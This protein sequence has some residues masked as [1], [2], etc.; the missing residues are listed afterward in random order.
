MPITTDAVERQLALDEHLAAVLDA[1]ERDLVKAWALAWDE[2]AGDLRDTLAAIAEKYDE[3]EP[4]PRSAFARSARLT[5]ILAH[6]SD[7]LD[8]LA[9]DLGVRVVR[10]VAS[11]TRR[12]ADAQAEI[13]SAMLPPE[14]RL[15]KLTH[16]DTLALDAIVKRTTQQITS[17]RW[18]LSPRAYSA[19][20]RELVRGIAA[21]S[22][23]REVADRMVTRAHD[24]FDGGLA[25]AVNIA[26]TE[27]VDA[28][29]EAARVG[30]QRHAD[31]IAEWV[32]LAHLS[33]RTCR[34]C[35]GQNGTRHPM[36][37][38]GPLDHQS[39]RCSR[40]PVPKTWAE[41]GF[42]ELDEPDDDGVPDAEEW[43]ASLTEAEQR[44]ILGPRGFVAWRRGDYPM[45][46]WARRRRT[47]GWRDSF[48][49][50]TPP[51][52]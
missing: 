8:Q 40:M 22:G 25:R 38:P 36:S 39:G 1:Q 30:Q 52:V 42:D 44:R 49:P 31:V 47:S 48:V 50:S 29:R 19:V 15:T 12:A 26:R 46:E 33:P 2:V 14:F 21:G 35:I 20:R 41:L 7:Q 28:H 17:P 16:D 3:G 11:V 27:M 18:H 10:D 9:T 4:I 13:L 24:G 5:T 43:F 34:S 51:S 32:W 23:P 37:E 45:S 6:I